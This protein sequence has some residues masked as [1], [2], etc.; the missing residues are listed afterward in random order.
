[1]RRF[2]VILLLSLLWGVSAQ[3]QD[4]FST[5]FSSGIDEFVTYNEDTAIPN[6]SAKS[7]GFAEGSSWMHLVF[8][9][10][11]VAAS[12]STHQPMKKANDWL[13]TPAV[14]VVEGAILSFDVR[15]A[16]Y[17][18]GNVKV[19]DV[20]VMISTTGN[21]VDDFTT[22]L[23]DEC[24]ATKDW[25]TVVCEL[26]EYVGQTVYI[27][28][29]NNN[30]SKDLL[31]VDNL[32]VGVERVATVE[33]QYTKLQTNLSKG[34]QINAAVKAG[35]STTITSI[36]A[37]LTCGEF[38]TTANY[39]NLSIAPGESYDVVFAETLPAPTAGVPQ[40]FTITAVVNGTDEVSTQ[41]EIV[42]QAYQPTK[43]VLFEE[44]TGTWCPN[45]P[46]GHVYME[47]MDEKYPETF[48][49]VAAHQNDPMQY[50]DYITYTMSAIGS[51]FPL[52]RAN[53]LSSAICDPMDME[54]AYSQV[55]T[56]PAVADMAIKMEWVDYNARRVLLTST[57]TFALSANDFDVRLEYLV[58]ENDVNVPGDNRYAQLNN[59]AGGQMGRM[60]GYEMK[61][62]P[63]PAS[64]MFYQDVVR[65]AC[66]DKVGFGIRGSVPATI[67]R[68]VANEHSVEIELPASVLVPLN[69]EFVVLLV[70]YNTGEVYNAA[71]CKANIPEA[72][73]KV[74]GDEV[75]RVYAANG[76]VRV[77]LTTEANVE[78]NVY[79]VDG[80]E[81]ASA[82]PRRVSG[83]ATIDC[84]VNGNGVYLV[85]V[86]CDGVAK[87]YKVVL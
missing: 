60:G 28:I 33:A 22:H 29:I 32:F 63:V 9:K 73:E 75:A 40:Q 11:G 81:V 52:G 65:Y 87:A 36:D 17:N 4:V 64:E 7:Y 70:D 83:S 66:T 39:A 57:S 38:V 46:R 74:N 41:G 85:N 76:G 18:A 68:D 8:E 50:Y 55:I 80:R 13:V 26:D 69:C 2:S 86:V 6:A 34:Q 14:N 79:A 77:E 42:S 51:S 10:N 35:L 59:Y 20:G 44:Q 25:K 53:R 82:T 5:D 45:C 54:D 58:L 84:Q 12:N 67:T 31:L 48:I 21:T 27:A 62:N 37:T 71:A 61:S 47:M 43:R 56:R 23:V 30:T 3:A 16:A 72:V 15:T 19:A 78:V 1:M 49:G 24:E